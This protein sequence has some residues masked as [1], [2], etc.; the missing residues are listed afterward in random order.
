MVLVS[1][2]I[3]NWLESLLAIASVAHVGKQCRFAYKATH[4]PSVCNESAIDTF[5]LFHGDYFQ[6]YHVLSAVC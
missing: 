3:H 5:H 1:A 4:L 6:F 2:P